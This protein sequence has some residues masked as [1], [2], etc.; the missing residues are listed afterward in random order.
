MSSRYGVLATRA[1]NQYRRRD[2]VAYLG[3][4]YYLENTA[5]STDLWATDVAVDLAIRHG[6]ARCR[7]GAG[8][9]PADQRHARTRSHA[10]L[11]R[12]HRRARARR[13]HRATDRAG[14]CVD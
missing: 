14:P 5:A 8:P 11:A 13:K 9:S 3:L 7:P 4:R 2:V 6:D 10:R 1:L 12:N